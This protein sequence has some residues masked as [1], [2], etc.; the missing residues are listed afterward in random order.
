MKYI[1][2]RI[3]IG[4]VMSIYAAS[5]ACLPVCAEDEEDIKI[6]GIDDRVN[7][8]ESVEESD[9][10]VIY[11]SL[12]STWTGILG[13]GTRCYYDEAGQKVTGLQEIDGYTYFFNEEGILQSG[14]QCVGEKEYYFSI[15]TGERYEN[16]TEIIDEVEYSFDNEGNVDVILADIEKEEIPSNEEIVQKKDDVISMQDEKIKAYKVGWITDNTNGKKY[17][18]LPNGKKHTGWLSFGKTYYYCGDDGA[19]VHGKRQVGN[20]WYYFDE[21]GIRQ[22]SKWIVENGKK[23]YYALPDGKLRE[24]WLS[25]GKTYY[26]CRL[27]GDV[28]Y[29]KLK[30]EN[31]WYYFN[32]SGI[33]QQSKWITENGKKKYYALPDGKLRE[34]WLSFGKTYYYCRLGGD[35]AYGKLKI[36][37]AWYYFDELGVRQQNMWV[38]ENGKNKYYA[39]SD[40]KLRTGWLSF[41]TTYYY[42]KN[43]AEIMRSQTDYPI[44]GVKYTFDA[45]GVMKREG[46]WGSYNGN[47]YYKNPAKGMPYKN[48]WVSF[49]KTY[50]YA[51]A[52]GHMV[53]GWQTIGGYRYYFDPGT[54]IMARNTTIDGIR[55]GADGKADTVYAK[56]A[57]ILN[58]VG[59]NLSAAFNWSANMPYSWTSATAAPGSEWFANY[60]FTNGYGDCYVMAG[61]FC[62]LARALGYEA[63]QMDGYVPSRGG[64]RTPHSWVE[65]VINGST[66]VFDP[67]FTHETGR[68]GYQI[69]YGT[70]GTWIY[71]GYYR[72]N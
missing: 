47:K 41:G 36:R 17:Y 51:N 2:K 19:I 3:C 50:Y 24:G 16:R 13:D 72:M 55:I 56:A 37:N 49:G 67:D 7:D 29:G 38:K 70:S 53:S 43:D 25:F 22:Q 40:G 33:R 63:H 4:T 14:W 57:N 60:G 10:E 71:S 48:Q 66:Y 1:I 32:E 45:N 44:E 15:E 64:G 62:Y 20:A 28:A 46:G 54:K 31:S 11:E 61:S 35:V 5:I 9:E 30:I 42:C 58:R 18:I 21:L 27:G 52:K 68:N 23:K 34:G 8:E 69:S 59:W 26:Y 6:A 65:V 12:Y 39:L